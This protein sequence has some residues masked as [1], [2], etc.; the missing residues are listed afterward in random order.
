[1]LFL[2]LWTNAKWI[3]HHEAY[4]NEHCAEQGVGGMGVM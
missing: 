4:L 3:N 2:S 1:M